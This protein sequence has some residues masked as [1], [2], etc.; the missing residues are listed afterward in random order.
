MQKLKYCFKQYSRPLTQHTAPTLLHFTT[1]KGE[2]T[3]DLT[4]VLIMSNTSPR[5]CAKKNEREPIAFNL[6]NPKCNHQ[7][8]KIRC[9]DPMVAKHSIETSNPIHCQLSIKLTS[10]LQ[11]ILLIPGD[12]GAGTLTFSQYRN[13]PAF[14]QLQC[15]RSYRER[16][17]EDILLPF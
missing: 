17:K 5:L 14:A 15:D 16:T 11:L 13:V 9:Q 3:K 1:M 6:W 4:Y 8:E 12:K 10:Y 7:R 2:G